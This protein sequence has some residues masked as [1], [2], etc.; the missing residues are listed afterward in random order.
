MPFK[1]LMVVR[2]WT[3]HYFDFE[4]NGRRCA[5]GIDRAGASRSK[6]LERGIAC[7]GSGKRAADGTRSSAQRARWQRVEQQPD[8]LIASPFIRSRANRRTD[9]RTGRW[10]L[11]TGRSTSSPTSAR[12]CIGTTKET[13]QPWVDAYWHACDPDY[14]DGSDAE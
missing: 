1:E 3:E 9:P 6:R 4:R 2:Y 13:R 10:R 7:R 12:R 8:L 14:L 5:A 11:Q